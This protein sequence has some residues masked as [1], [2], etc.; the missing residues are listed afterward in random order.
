MTYNDVFV[1]KSLVDVRSAY[2]VCSIIQ[3]LCEAQ[4]MRPDIRLCLARPGPEPGS[5]SS[6]FFS[7]QVQ[8]KQASV[9]HSQTTTT[10]PSYH[11]H[12]TLLP[13]LAIF[14]RGSN[15]AK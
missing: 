8:L 1:G 12:C 13:H 2:I 15:R 6:A 5:S 3:S 7:S 4:S 9:C 10:H 14:N 11:H